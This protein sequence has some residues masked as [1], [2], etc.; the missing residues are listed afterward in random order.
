MNDGVNFGGF[1][2]EVTQGGA[3]AIPAIIRDLARYGITVYQSGLSASD[4]N[5]AS[6]R[7]W[8]FAELSEILRGVQYV[9]RAL[10]EAKYPIQTIVADNR[11]QGFFNQVMGAFEIRRVQNGYL[12]PGTDG[13]NGSA[14]I[15]CTSVGQNTIVFYGNVNVSQYTLVHELGH[16]FNN[17]SDMG[18][19]ATVSLH[20]RM[21]QAKVD[22]YGSPAGR[23]FGQQGSDWVRG[24]RGWGSGPSSPTDFQQNAYEVKDVDASSLE[25]FT[26]I[27]E[28]TADMF[29]N[30]VY[31]VVTDRKLGFQNISWLGAGCQTAAGCKQETERP[32]D[33]RFEWMRGQMSEIFSQH[34]DWQ[35]SS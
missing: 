3:Q 18:G 10:Y 1:N 17:R 16:F 11:I 15:A 24:K 23:V 9:A 29:L 25:R 28:A 8:T 33:A 35:L 13:C 22:D 32:G 12:L 19:A 2:V 6:Q 21:A 27:D 14:N 26:E 4:P 31:S 34:P 20:A 5:V 30:W 7:A